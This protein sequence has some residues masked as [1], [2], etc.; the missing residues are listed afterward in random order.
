M[1]GQSLCQRAAAF[2]VGLDRKNQFLH[3]RIFM[4]IADD[5]E[6]LDQRYACGKHGRELPAE[7]SDVPRRYLRR[8][9]EEP[10]A[11]L[12]D[13]A[14]NDTLTPQIGAHCGLVRRHAFAFDLFAPFVGSFPHERRALR[15][16]C[17]CHRL[18]L[19]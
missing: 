6:C 11:L 18:T 4:T 7:N 5:L 1:L 13:P 14:G 17:L 8:G 9:A 16:R 15:C 10:L 19:P 3:G 12:F 2:N